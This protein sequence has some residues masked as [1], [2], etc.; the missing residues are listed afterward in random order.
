MRGTLLKK[1]AFVKMGTFLE[2]GA[3]LKT[4]LCAGRLWFFSLTPLVRSCRRFFVQ[5]IFV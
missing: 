4:G 3:F 5:M 2:M 1:D